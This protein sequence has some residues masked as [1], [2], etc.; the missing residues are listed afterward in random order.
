MHCERNYPLRKM[1]SCLDVALPSGARDAEYLT[2]LAL[3]LPLALDYAHADIA[4]YLAGVDVAAGDRFGKLELS[5]DGVRARDA[6][7]VETVRSRSVP[8]AIVLGGGYAPTRERTARLHAE[9]FRAALEYEH[10]QSS[11]RP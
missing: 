2:E 5:D 6:Y 11:S 3:H 8:L 9:V 4:F 7:V 10:H 1:R